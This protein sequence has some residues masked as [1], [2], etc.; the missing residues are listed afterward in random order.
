[1]DIFR[2]DSWIFQGLEVVSDQ[3]KQ[4]LKE[5]LKME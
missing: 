1:M 3:W 4:E 5:T 2:S